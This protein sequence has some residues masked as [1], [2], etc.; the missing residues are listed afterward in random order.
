MSN[1][2]RWKR[3][4]LELDGWTCQAPDCDA[5]TCLDAAHIR[6][7]TQPATRHDPANGVTLCRGHHQY[8]HDHPK[9][10]QRFAANFSRP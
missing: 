3:A 7:R 5:N 1:D 2:A 9:E 4:V 6:P 8:Y 10:F